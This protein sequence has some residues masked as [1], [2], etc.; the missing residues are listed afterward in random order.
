MI[1]LNELKVITERIR[2]GLGFECNLVVDKHFRVLLVRVDLA[3]FYE[4]HRFLE[5]LS[6]RYNVKVE[7]NA[8]TSIAKIYI[9]P[10]K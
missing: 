8:L 10:K 6:S 2:F 4:L 7:I 9:D 3:R 5:S 1:S